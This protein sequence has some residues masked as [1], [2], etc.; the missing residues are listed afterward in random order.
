MRLI[1]PR[2]QSNPEIFIGMSRDGLERHLLRHEQYT[3]NILNIHHDLEAAYVRGYALAS[4]EQNQMHLSMTS[5]REK[6]REIHLSNLW[7]GHALGTFTGVDMDTFPDDYE[8]TRVSEIGHHPMDLVGLVAGLLY[9]LG[10]RINT[11]DFPFCFKPIVPEKGL[12]SISKKNIDSAKRYF[13][14]AR[15]EMMDQLELPRTGSLT[16]KDC[17]KLVDHLQ[18][19]AITEPIYA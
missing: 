10:T 3:T 15:L 13:T 16:R 4:S 9:S 18:E 2:R 6:A 8:F 11:N 7:Y 5:K 12:P 19:V 1:R 17:I 14:N